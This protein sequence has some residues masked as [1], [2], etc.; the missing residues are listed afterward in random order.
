VRR[1]LEDH[2][3]GRADFGRPL[4]GLINLL[5]WHDNYIS[6]NCYRSLIRPARAARRIGHFD[7]PAAA[8]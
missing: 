2:W 4:W 1:M 5:I 3:A 7:L 6:S 8:Q